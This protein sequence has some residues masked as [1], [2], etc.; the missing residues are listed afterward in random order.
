MSNIFDDKRFIKI[1]ESFV[2]HND[3]K[4]AQEIMKMVNKVPTM[5][6]SVISPLYRGIA[7]PEDVVTAI[8]SEGFTFNKITSWSLSQKVA[9]SFIADEKKK[10]RSYKGLVGVVFRSQIPQN[11]II[12]NIQGLVMSGSAMGL[13]PNFDPLAMDSAIKEAEV[14]VMPGVTIRKSNII[15]KIKL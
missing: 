15:K 14:L 5:F 6:R 9:E 11:K 1:V 7:L 13:L 4:D 2:E 12:L 8:D 10:L 3:Q